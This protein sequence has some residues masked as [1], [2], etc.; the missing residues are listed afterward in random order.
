LNVPK[1]K[2]ADIPETRH[3]PRGLALA[4]FVFAFLVFANTINQYFIMDD[5]EVIS[6]VKYNKLS[7]ALLGYDTVLENKFFR[8]I[9]MLCYWIQYKLF[10]AAPI[11]FHTISVLLHALCAIAATNLFFILFGDLR[12]AA[13]F[14]FVFVSFPNHSEVVNWPSINFTS[15]DAL[16]YLLSLNLFGCYRLSQKNRFLVLSLCSFLAAIL[17]KES[18]FTL[19]LSLILF[20]FFF[21]RQKELEVPFAKKAAEYFLYFGVL[22]VSLH[23]IQT[24][25]H[26][27]YGYRTVEGESLVSLYFGNPYLFATDIIRLY[28][29]AWKYLLAP[30]SPQ[31]PFQRVVI[32]LTITLMLIA[33]GICIWR[34]RITF[35]PL[36]YSFIFASITALPILGTFKVLTLT[37]WIRFLYLPS[38][39]GCY[40]IALTL[41]GVS[42]W[43]RRP[44]HVYV[45]LG[46]VMVPVIG[47]CKFYDNQWI[48]AQRENKEIMETLIAEFR[49][50]PAYSRVYV[51]GVPWAEKEIPRIDYALPGAVAIYYDR[52]VL[53]AGLNFL[54]ANKIVALERETYSGEDWRYYLF[55]WNAQT[56]TLTQQGD[57]QPE[58]SDH[59]VRITWEFDGPLAQRYLAPGKDIYMMGAASSTPTFKVTGPWAFLWLPWVDSRRPI[60]Y[61]TL[62]MMLSADGTKRDIARIFWV[63]GDEPD[64]TGG[65]SIGFFAVADGRFH[66]YKIPM[67]RNGLSVINPRIFRLAIRPSQVSDTLCSVRKM[68]VEYY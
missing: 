58:T 64:V 55:T 2:D 53:Q 13:I 24:F 68:T 50:L 34:R 14:G 56:K 16:F 35:H 20:D 26:T 3:I 9:P 66:E 28:M 52:N 45:L 1:T 37:H 36:A 27:G 30:F 51:L 59:P 38:V 41:D 25:L 47:L 6:S 7:H 44:V 31:L 4:L 10:G 42:R 8:P 15:W 60:K 19:P 48:Q 33:C 49:S 11:V 57:I 67:Y 62:E 5:F 21:C 29:R 63:S 61:V 46:I 32:S 43:L 22:F 18:A 23:I 54:P 12:S 17:S 39:G 65:K 40:I